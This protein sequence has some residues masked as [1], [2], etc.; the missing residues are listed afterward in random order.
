[1][2]EGV[3]LAIADDDIRLSIE[4]GLEELRDLRSVVLEVG[5]R[6]DDDVGPEPAAGISPCFTG[7]DRPR[8]ERRSDCRAGT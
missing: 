1:M 2:V 4:D 5:V 8:R 7:I 6:V 3:D